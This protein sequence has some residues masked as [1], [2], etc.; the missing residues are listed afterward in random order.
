MCRIY[1]HVYTCTETCA[2]ICVVY[3]E[4]EPQQEETYPFAQEATFQE[5]SEATS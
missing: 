1:T 2:H 4:G 3:G 5:K